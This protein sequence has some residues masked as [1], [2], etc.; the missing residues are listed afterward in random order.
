MWRHESTKQ[1]SHAAYPNM[2]KNFL[3]L[4]TSIFSGRSGTRQASQRS[5]A[6]VW[7]MLPGSSYAWT[8]LVHYLSCMGSGIVSTGHRVFYISPRRKSA[9]VRALVA[10][11][12]L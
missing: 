10:L 9:E 1:H 11:S 3:V 7:S 8:R 2:S 6:F 12:T 5:V 4:L